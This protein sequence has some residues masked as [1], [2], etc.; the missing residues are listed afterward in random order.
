MSKTITTA[1][2]Q[3]VC[4][5]RYECVYVYVFSLLACFAAAD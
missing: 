3:Y 1:A 2:A 5:F 4:I